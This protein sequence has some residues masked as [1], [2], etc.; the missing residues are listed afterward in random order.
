MESDAARARFLK[1]ISH[2]MSQPLHALM[3]YLSALDRRLPEGEARAIL[4]RADQSAQALAA[5]LENLAALTRIE[6]GAVK[7]ALERVALQ[8]LF[9]AAVARQPQA[10]ADATKLYVRS[11]PALLDQILHNLVSNAIRHG[12]G[13]A[14]LSAIEGDGAVELS[15]SDQGAG[16]ASEDQL[17]AFEAFERL[18]GA[19]PHGLGLGLAIVR[20]LSDLLGHEIELRSTPGQ[21]A[22][23]IVRAPRA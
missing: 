15:V 2:D 1:A 6:A 9:D 18:E 13:S 22:T 16:I 23:F 20:K 10:V 11:D 14:R 19:S 3:L 5:M 17:R 8:E 12:G 21:G 4:R 7:P